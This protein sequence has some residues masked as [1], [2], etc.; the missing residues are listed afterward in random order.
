M[1]PYARQC[2]LVRVTGVLIFARAR[3]CAA[4]VLLA[5]GPVSHLAGA[6]LRTR[7]A[8]AGSE[9][10]CRDYPPAWRP[11]GCSRPCARTQSRS[12]KPGRKHYPQSPCRLRAA[13]S[14]I[15]QAGGDHAD[16]PDL[17][18][19]GRRAGLMRVCRI[20]GRSGSVERGR[21]RVFVTRRRRDAPSPGPVTPPQRLK[22]SGQRFWLGPNTPRSPVRTYPPDLAAHPEEAGPG[23]HGAAILT[24]WTRLSDGAW[25]R[26][27]WSRA[28]RR[29]PRPP[30]SARVEL[31][32]SALDVDALL[33]Q[34][35]LKPQPN[36]R[37]PSL[38]RTIRP[39]LPAHCPFRAYLVLLPWKG[40][41][42]VVCHWAV[43][44]PAR[45]RPVAAPR[46][47]R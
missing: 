18:A 43:P 29:G 15:V 23:P 5:A 41:A 33:D 26:A 4:L 46:R 34:V 3:T 47:S 40:A 13:G 32:V 8:A 22:R 28:Q 10:S 17:Y 39:A 12:G 21:L 37:K 1:P 19:F 31:V 38:T 16:H 30:L 45:P 27:G 42:R 11:S 44:A 6:R 24:S 7:R 25:R 36:Q 35:D 2:R 9:T 20:D 14:W